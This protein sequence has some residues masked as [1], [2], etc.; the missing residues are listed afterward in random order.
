MGGTHVDCPVD[1]I[2]E[3]GDHRV[4]TA[5]AHMYDASISQVAQGI[6]KMIAKVVSGFRHY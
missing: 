4:V 6:E 5:P 1:A 2:V 3:D